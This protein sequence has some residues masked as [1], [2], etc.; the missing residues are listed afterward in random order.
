MLRGV[1]LTRLMVLSVDG[2]I[3][4]F[5]GSAEKSFKHSRDHALGRSYIELLGP[6]RIAQPPARQH[7]AISTATGKTRLQKQAVTK[8]RWSST[9]R[10][11]PVDVRVPWHGR[12]RPV[13]CDLHP[14]TSPT[15]SKEHGNHP[16]PRRSAGCLS[17]KIPLFRMM[18]HE[19]SHAADGIL[20]AIHLLHDDGW[21]QSS[22]NLT[23]QGRAEIR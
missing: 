6:A 7:R 9:G 17:G 3:I 10:I 15:S 11:F 16:R 21:T 14:A 18:S 12:R 13:F 2:E 1:R 8:Q 5:N 23:W 19:P 22:A 4:D 20:S